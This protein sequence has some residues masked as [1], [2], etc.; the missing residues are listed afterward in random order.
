V[1]Q[2]QAAAAAREEVRDMMVR[3]EHGGGYQDVTVV[4][5][6]V[7]RAGETVRIGDWEGE[8]IKV[9]H[10]AMANASGKQYQDGTDPAALLVLSGSHQVGDG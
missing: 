3:I 4:M 6:A 7:P 9:T 1:P 2:A 10:V 5:D 8:V